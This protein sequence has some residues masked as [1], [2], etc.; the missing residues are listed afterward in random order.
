[1]EEDPHVRCIFRIRE[2]R[3]RIRVP[4]QPSALRGVRGALTAATRSGRIT[5]EGQPDRQWAISTG[6]SAVDVAVASPPLT[7][8]AT[9]GSGSVQVTGAAVNGT[10]SKRAVNGSVGSGGRRF[11]SPRPAVPSVSRSDVEPTR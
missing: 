6:S 11:G 1:M 4:L 10:V 9:T 3:A 7:L 8:E 2:G 5:V